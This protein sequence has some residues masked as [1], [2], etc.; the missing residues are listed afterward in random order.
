[1]ALERAFGSSSSMAVEMALPRC[2]RQHATH[3]QRGWTLTATGL[4]R[5]VCIASVHV[6]HPA[7]PAGGA[8][9]V[10]LIDGDWA[11]CRAA[12]ALPD[13]EGAVGVVGPCVQDSARH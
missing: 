1:M 13:H 8:S 3:D 9:I 4:I 2:N 11:Y 6:A 10:S 7:D 12:I 5:R